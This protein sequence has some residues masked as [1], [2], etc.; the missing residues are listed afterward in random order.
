MRRHCRAVLVAAIVALPGTA[1]AVD[2]AVD[3]AERRAQCVSWMMAGYPSG[4]EET[5]CSRQFALPSPFMFKCM[6]AE[7]RGYAS[8]TQ[9]RACVL[10]LTRAAERAEQGYVRD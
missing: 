8:E 4:L 7:R 9:R 1:P 6:R 3:L 5:A 10:F 2:M